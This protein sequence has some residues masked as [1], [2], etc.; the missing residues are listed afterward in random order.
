[1]LADALIFSYDLAALRGRIA[2]WRA[3]NGRPRNPRPPREVVDP[4]IT[5]WESLRL[6]FRVFTEREPTGSCT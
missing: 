1:V 3:A 5:F 2:G 4:R 6:R